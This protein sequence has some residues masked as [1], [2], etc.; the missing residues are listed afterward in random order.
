MPHTL[1][2]CLQAKK[3]SWQQKWMLQL[4]KLL[5]IIERNRKITAKLP[6]RPS[7]RS[8]ST[9]QISSKDKPAWH[10]D[11]SFF[12]QDTTQATMPSQELSLD[13]VS[14]S[15]RP[16]LR[17]SGQ[18]A[19]KGFPPPYP[20]RYSPGG[21]RVEPQAPHAAPHRA[22]AKRGN[23]LQRVSPGP[24]LFYLVLILLVNNG[25]MTQSTAAF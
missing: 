12:T 11:P 4:G 19:C 13:N 22:V 16:L 6:L 14:R 24:L 25:L 17:A 15:H 8:S 1:C 5:Y 3:Q 9:F 10:R 23:A 2:F 21:S 20:S 18:S 7:Q